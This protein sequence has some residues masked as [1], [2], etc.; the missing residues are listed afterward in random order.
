MIRVLFDEGGD[1]HKDVILKIDAVP[2][3]IKVVD[4]YYLYDFLQEKFDTKEESIIEFLNYIK[5][6]VLQLN[7]KRTFIVI[8]LSDEYIAGL[9][10]NRNR[11]GNIKTQYVWT[12]ELQGYGI[13]QSKLDQQIAEIKFESEN[14]N[15]WLL[16]Q[17]SLINGIDWSVKR[18]K[19]CL[20][21]RL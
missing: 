9:L 6:T 11:D 16:S 14:Q 13:S 3:F 15:E 5:N 10:M 20:Q 8:D 17:D 12:R 1:S 4:S 2:T 21:Q 7:E 18:I 19:N